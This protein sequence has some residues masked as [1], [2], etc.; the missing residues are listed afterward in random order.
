MKDYST[1]IQV[2]TEAKELLSLPDNNF[3][4]SSWQDANDALAE[5]DGILAK[6]EAGALSDTRQLQIIF[7]PTGSLQELSISSG[8]YDEFIA[9]AKDFDQ[10][11]RAYTTTD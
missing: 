11:L 3:V 8:W 7:A 2:F 1:L 9:L 10:A 5:I 6:L 4:W